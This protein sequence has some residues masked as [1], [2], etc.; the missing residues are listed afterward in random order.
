MNKLDR[1]G[2]S[3]HASMLSV[4]AHRIHPN[5]MVIT[6]PV[7][8]FDPK[9]YR[10]AEPGIEG[11]VDLVKWEVWRW[12]ADGT[13]SRQTLPKSDSVADFDM[14]PA[15]HPLVPTLL[16]A[17]A[18]LLE[19]LSMFS[20]ELMEQ[21]LDLPAEPTANLSISPPTVIKHL[22]AATLRGDVLPI[23]CGS[24]I[25]HVGTDLVL[26]YAGELLASPLD[27]PHDE[28]SDKS[29]VRMLAWKV[30]WDKKKGWM[31]FV[32]IY[33]GLLQTTR[34]VFAFS[35]PVVIRHLEDAYDVAQFNA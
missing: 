17:R 21:L 11:I 28:Q 27:V 6:L 31:T 15:D 4:L 16:P 30:S 20:D 34:F 19:N 13:P 24:A 14:F 25:R 22:R 32:K 18:T 5:P 33:S 2:S 29:Q 7:A 10:M 9:N 8:S 3:Y 35:D 1:P 23:F 26:D 12:A